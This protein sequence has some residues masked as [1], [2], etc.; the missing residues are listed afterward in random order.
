MIGLFGG[1]FDPV[2]HGHLQPANEVMRA[3]GLSEIR[4]IP[5]YNPPHRPAPAASAADR[6]AMTRLAI[7]DT[8]G[9]VVD[10]C[11]IQRKGQSYTYDTVVYVTRMYPANG[12]CLLIGSD[13]FLTL[14]SWH[15]WTELMDRINIIVMHRPGV[16]LADNLPEWAQGHGCHSLSEFHETQSGRVWVQQVTPVD[17]SATNIRA[18]LQNNHS[19]KDMLP[20][21]VED[22]IRIHHLY[23]SA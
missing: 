9:F 10:D 8:P 15:R 17:V 2:H 7:N 12:F 13:A 5:A 21:S 20:A 22:Y 3:V 19:V 1:T 4:F 18:A 16:A 23:N 11:E 6:L 14:N